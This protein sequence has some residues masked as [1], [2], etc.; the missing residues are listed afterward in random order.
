M[1]SPT[2]STLDLRRYED[3]EQAGTLA[4]D[5]LC[6]TVVEPLIAV[7]GPENSAAF[8][9][10]FLLHLCAWLVAQI[11]HDGAINV[12]QSIEKAIRKDATNSGRGLH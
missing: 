5:E 10:A 6:K 3:C 9:R 1:T 8:I 12:V 7:S 4:A 11:G 2:D